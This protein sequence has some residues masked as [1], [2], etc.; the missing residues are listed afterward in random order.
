MTTVTKVS[1]YGSCCFNIQSLGASRQLIVRGRWVG[2]WR[3]IPYME[4]K[5]YQESQ[6]WVVRD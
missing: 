2:A 4:I 5:T 3:A 6:P 1:G